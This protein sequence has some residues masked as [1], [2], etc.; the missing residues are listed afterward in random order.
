MHAHSR[1]SKHVD[2]AA[3]QHPSQPYQSDSLHHDSSAHD[4]SHH[5]S[6]LHDSSHHGSSA[7]DSSQPARHHQRCLL[8]NSHKSFLNQQPVAFQEPHYR[9]DAFDGRYPELLLSHSG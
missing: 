2:H 6:S 5:G 8:L 7:H 3:H 4:S 1:Q 9:C